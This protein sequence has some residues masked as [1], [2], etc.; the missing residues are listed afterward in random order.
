MF[1][2]GRRVDVKDVFF[3]EP[4]PGFLVPSPDESIV[5]HSSVSGLVGVTELPQNEILSLLTVLGG[6][7]HST[8][9]RG[10]HPGTPPSC[11]I[12]TRSKKQ[13]HKLRSMTS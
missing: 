11:Q 9:D 6:L 7:R 2:D 5:K 3:F 4:V 1:G 10:F 8:V 13:G 12:G